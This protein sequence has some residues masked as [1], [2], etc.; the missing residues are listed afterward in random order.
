MLM[1]RSSLPDK[2]RRE[3]IMFYIAYM[4]PLLGPSPSEF[5]NNSTPCS[6]LSDDHTT[7]EL[8]WAIEQDG[9][10]SVRFALE[11]V[12]PL[13]GS[14]SPARSCI[15]ALQSL[16]RFRRIKHFDLK[17]AYTCFETLTYEQIT[18]SAKDSRHSSQFFLGTYLDFFIL[19][20]SESA[21]L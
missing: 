16:A 3:Y 2:L 21:V 5:Q 11:P 19:H 12:S 18:N 6:F 4:I 20:F 17:W 8:I 1:E 14:P 9:P 10:P 13:D 15:S 7:V